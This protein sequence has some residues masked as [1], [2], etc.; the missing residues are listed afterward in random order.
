MLN[1]SEPNAGMSEMVKAERC[2]P[3]YEAMITKLKERYDR[4][5]KFQQAALAYFEGRTARNKMAE[6]I[7]EL[8]T[9]SNMLRCELD[10]LIKQQEEDQ[11]NKEQNNKE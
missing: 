3:D 4:T 10:S 1:D 9:K 2:R 11:D 5:F 7:G 8:V 6:L